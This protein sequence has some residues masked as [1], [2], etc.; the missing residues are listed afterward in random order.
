M[1]HAALHPFGERVPRLLH[2]RQIDED[3][4]PALRLVRGDAANRAP[5]GLRTIRD[6]R[7][8]GADDRVDERRLAD[9]GTAGEAGEAG[10]GAHCVLRSRITASCN[11]SISPSSASW[12]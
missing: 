4:L 2:A 3:H 6:D 5:G 1:L 11:F 8:L 7:D 10:S 12:S 9:V